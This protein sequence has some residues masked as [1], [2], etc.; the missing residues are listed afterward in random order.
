MRCEVK[1]KI[2]FD[3]FVIEMPEEWSCSSSNKKDIQIHGV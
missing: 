3:P 2:N 1:A